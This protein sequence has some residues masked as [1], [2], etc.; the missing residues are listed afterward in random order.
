MD[1]EADGVESTSSLSIVESFG[2]RRIS[3]LRKLRADKSKMPGFPT[4]DEK[5]A[6]DPI[7]TPRIVIAQVNTIHIGTRKL[8]GFLKTK[9]PGPLK[10]VLLYI[11]GL[12]LFFICTSATSYFGG[13]GV[14]EAQTLEIVYDFL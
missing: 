3:F 13:Q 14:K 6:E 1:T 12:C 2:C 4:F 11:L 9:E 7:D 10:D 5:K 8:H